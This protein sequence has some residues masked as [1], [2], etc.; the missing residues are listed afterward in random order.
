MSVDPGL[1]DLP[2]ENDTNVAEN[3]DSLSL[4]RI[5]GNTT[6]QTQLR[7]S[8]SREPGSEVNRFPLETASVSFTNCRVSVNLR[9]R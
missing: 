4:T 5:L 2:A 6:R 3:S 7:D 8:V 9:V 1:D